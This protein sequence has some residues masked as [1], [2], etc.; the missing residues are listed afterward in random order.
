MAALAQD[1]NTRNR[2]IERTADVPVAAS[3]TIYKGAM[4]SS[5]A[6][7]FA[8]PASDTAAEVV[9]G[10]ADFQVDNSAGADADLTVRVS[11]GVFAISTLGTVIDQADL[12]RPVYVSDDNNVEKIAGVANN[13]PAGY[14]D[15]IEV[16]T[17]LFWIKITEL[18]VL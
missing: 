17:G 11:K 15:E 13:I 1:R 4:V 14:L 16:D 8:V 7:G 10:I 5:N 6:T 2:Q 3:T 18:Y 12:G 9:I